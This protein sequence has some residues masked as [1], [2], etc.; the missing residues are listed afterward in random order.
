MSQPVRVRVETSAPYEVRIGCGLL[1]DLASEFADRDRVC[2]LTDENVERLHGAALSGFDETARIVV[3]PGEDSKRFSRLELV[4]D[5]LVERGL[6][7]ASCLVAFGGGVVGDLGGLAASLYQRGIDVIQIPTTLLAQ[8]DSSVGGKTAVNLSGGKNLAGTFHQPARVWADCATLATLPV[9]EFQ[10]GLGEV[11][12]SAL[13]GDQGLLDVLNAEHEAILARDGSALA[14]IVERCVRV[15][16]GVVAQ[17][18]HEGGI[19]KALNLGHTFAH[20]IEHAAGYG[21]IPHGVA[22]AVGLVLAT[23]ASATTG[24]CDATL[25]GQLTELMSHYSLPT[26]L[27]SLRTTYSTELSSPALREGMRHDKKGSSGDPQFVLLKAAEQIEI[28][29]SLDSSLLDALLA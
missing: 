12:K 25:E 17:D 9:D 4:L 26:T 8:V 2:V 23:R 20:A 29:V 28:D 27:D 11:I 13:I 24:L 16:A 3:P 6:S 22:V 5:G 15:K 19:R 14:Q 1:H 7:R 21:T 18:E 10:S